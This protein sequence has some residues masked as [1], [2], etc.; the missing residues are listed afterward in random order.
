MQVNVA[1]NDLDNGSWRT[2]TGSFGD[3]TGFDDRRAMAVDFVVEADDSTTLASRW[4]STLADFSK[5]NPRVVCKL[6]ATD[7]NALADLSPNDGTHNSV[8][9]SIEALGSSEQT[10]HSMVGRLHIMAELVMPN[11]GGGTGSNITTY[12]G[13]LGTLKR[14]TNYSAGRVIGKAVLATFVATFDEDGGGAFT[15]TSVENASGKARFV[16]T[17]SVPPTFAPGMRLKVTSGTGY[18]GVHLIT[19]I[20][21]ANKKI[22]TDTA[23]SATATGSAVIGTL[24]TG[25]A[26]FAAART[27]ILEDILGCDADGGRDSTTGLS[28]VSEKREDNDEDG[29]Q[30]TVALESAW[31]ELETHAAQRELT[32][33]IAEEQPEEWETAA[34]GVAPVYIYVQGSVT[35]D[36]EVLVAANADL[37]QLFDSDVKAAVEA[38]VVD[39]VNKGPIR[40]RRRKI[41]SNLKESRLSFELV[42]QARN[43]TVIS[44]TITREERTDDNSV[45]YRLMDG[46]DY[47]QRPKGLPPKYITVVSSRASTDNSQPSVPTPAGDGAGAIYRESSQGSSQRGPITTPFGVVWVRSRSV[48][49]VRRVYKG[50]GQGVKVL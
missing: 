50:G 35:M 45:H 2:I 22:T 43:L 46:H 47:D 39:Q 3:A 49:F 10:I 44:A 25:A 23:Y 33:S 13:L 24:T 31:S 8:K 5:L 18:V 28:L 21:V 36:R 7:A 27:S 29:N 1:G 12:T 9:T 6:A 16:A 30:Y 15:I 26:N 17:V 48:V 38:H 37:H 41:T 32:I 20:D 40:L 11:A 4:A 42:Y 14:I 19:A 34:G